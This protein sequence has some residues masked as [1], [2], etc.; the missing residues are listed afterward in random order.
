MVKLKKTFIEK[1]K[2][3]FFKGTKQKNKKSINNTNGNNKNN[4][5]LEM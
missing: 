5:N 4:D 2:S 3:L 1:L